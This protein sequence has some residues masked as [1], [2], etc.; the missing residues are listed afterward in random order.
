M[1]YQDKIYGQLEISELVVLKLLK[2]PQMQRLKKIHQNGIYFYFLPRFST[3]RFEHSVGVMLLLK[4]FKASLAEQVAGLLHDI[5]HQVFSH[6]IDYFYNVSV[7]ADYQDSIHQGVINDQ[8][9]TK[10]LKEHGL[11][12]A[13]IGHLANWP[14]LDNE[15]PNLCADRLDYTLRDALAAGLANKSLIREVVNNL[16]VDD[17]GFVFKDFASAYFLA[18]LSLKM[19]E[20]VWH[21]HWGELSFYLMGEILKYAI[22]RKLISEHDF[23]LGDA[24]LLNKLNFLKDD[25]INFKLNFIKRIKKINI[26]GDPDSYDLLLPYKFRVIDPWVKNKRLT[27]LDAEFNKNFKAASAKAKIGHYF[28][29]KV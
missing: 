8:A 3:N 14:L 1:F 6:V 9:I 11:S 19:Q 26:K 21:S 22:S 5:S 7:S 28:K 20:E 27:E 23:W 15:L 13:Q 17:R 25:W 12:L 2:L 16:S 29:F 18:N 4:K 24:E 10:I